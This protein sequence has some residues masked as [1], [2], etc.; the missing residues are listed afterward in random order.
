ME[1]EV[2]QG[3][4]AVSSLL[5]IRHELPDLGHLPLGKRTIL[6]CS[7]DTLDD[8]AKAAGLG[9]IDVL[10][11]DV[12]GNELRVFQGGPNVLCRTAVVFVELS[13][14]PLYHGSCLFQEVVDHLRGHGLLLR[15]LVPEFYSADHEL[16]Q[17]NG[18][19]TRS[20]P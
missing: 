8:V 11:V 7:V 5:P 15:D 16:L 3:S 14:Q 9:A 12:Q 20:A 4:P 2:W 18:L 10:K 6:P 19:F 1:L 13:F 17:V